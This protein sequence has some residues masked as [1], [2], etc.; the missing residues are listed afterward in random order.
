MVVFLADKK[1]Q[2]K[3]NEFWFH[4]DA[5]GLTAFKCRVVLP[6]GHIHVYNFHVA[7]MCGKSANSWTPEL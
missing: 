2:R 4:V 3:V 7:Y 5:V 6:D 1:F